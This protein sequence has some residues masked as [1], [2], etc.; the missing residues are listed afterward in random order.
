MPT[1]CRKL[2]TLWKHVPKIS[3]SSSHMSTRYTYNSLIFLVCDSMCWTCC[4]SVNQVHPIP[5]NRED[6][7][8]TIV[9]QQDMAGDFWSTDKMGWLG[10]WVSACSRYRRRSFVFFLCQYAIPIATLE[11]IQQNS[12]NIYECTRRKD[13]RRGSICIERQGVA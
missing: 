8:K 13:R 9:N 10:F 12:M 7:L 2:S 11:R 5:V 4:G 6:A 3:G 1:F